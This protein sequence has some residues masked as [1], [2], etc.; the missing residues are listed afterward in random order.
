MTQEN[1]N[2]DNASAEIIIDQKFNE[3]KLHINYDGTGAE[4]CFKLSQLEQVKSNLNKANIK[5]AVKKIEKTNFYN[6]MREIFKN[7]FLK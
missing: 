3:F 7:T 6:E 4:Y 5:D 2:F 1:F